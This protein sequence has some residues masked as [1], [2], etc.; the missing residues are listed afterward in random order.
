MRREEQVRLLCPS[1][2]F[3]PCGLSALYLLQGLGQVYA[4]L[5]RAAKRQHPDVLVGM[6]AHKSAGSFVHSFR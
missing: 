1:G 3:V 5:F 6:L 2:Q 4:G